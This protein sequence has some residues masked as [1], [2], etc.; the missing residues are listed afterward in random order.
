MLALAESIVATVVDSNQLKLE[1]KEVM[2]INYII[3][4]LPAHQNNQK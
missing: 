3:T 2:V 1:E 4:Q